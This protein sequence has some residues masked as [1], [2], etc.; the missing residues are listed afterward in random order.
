MDIA[1]GEVSCKHCNVSR[2]GVAYYA[3]LCCYQWRTQWHALT[4]KAKYG[5]TALEATQRNAEYVIRMAEKQAAHDASLVRA[6]KLD[7][8]GAVYPA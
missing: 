6:G 1:N 7:S 4:S 8:A 5:Y 2:L 3:T